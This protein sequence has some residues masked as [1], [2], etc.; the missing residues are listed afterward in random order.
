MKRFIRKVLR[1]IDWLPV[2]WHLDEYDYAYLYQVMEKQLDRMYDFFSSDKP[3]AEGSDLVAKEI[4]LARNLIARQTYANHILMEEVLKDHKEK[5]GESIMI[6]DDP[7]PD[8]LEEIWEEECVYDEEGNLMGSP[9]LFTYENVTNFEEWEEA[10]KES[11]KAFRE[12]RRVE[13]EEH[14]KLWDLLKERINAWWD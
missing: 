2:I 6:L 10:S 1:V 9:L 5:Y 8:Y 7:I 11:S 13:E 3:L 14:N 4:K 12:V